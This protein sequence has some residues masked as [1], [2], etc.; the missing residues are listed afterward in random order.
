[1]KLRQYTLAGALALGILGGSNPA[2]LL[3]EFATDSPD[4]RALAEMN[5]CT[6]GLAGGSATP[7]GRPL[8]WKNRDVGN[9]NQEFHYYNDGRIP[10]I[11]VTYRNEVDEY[12]GGINA[13]GFAVENSNSYNLGGGA[14]DAGDW[15]HGGDDDGFIHTLA[16][17]TCRTVDDFGR[18]MDSLNVVGR[19]LTCNY[20]TI[21]AYGGAAMF[22]TAAY[23]YRRWDAI[24]SPEGFIVRSNY[25]YSGN[26]VNNRVGYWGPHRYDAAYALFKS[27]V[28]RNNL[29]P[30]YIYQNVI[31]NLSIEGLE[32]PTLPLNGYVP[33]YPFGCI[34]NGEAICRN[35]TRSVLVVQ[36]VRNGE[37]PDDAVMWAMAGSPLTA[38][39]V[40]VWVR[41]G[42]VPVELDGPNGSRICD[43]TISLQSKVYLNGAVNTWNL[44]NPSHTGLWDMTKPLEQW[45]Y[46][47]TQRFIHSPEFSY[48]QLEVFQ[49][50]M[51]RQVADSLANF[52]WATQVTEVTSPVFL[53]SNVVM[54][55]WTL[56][57][58]GYGRSP[59]G[60][61]IYR[62]GEPFREGLVG[63]P[64]AYTESN[65]FTD[66]DAPDQSCFYRVEAVF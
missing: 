12:Y 54:F 52:K 19:S 50:E 51:A 41:A 14:Y 40:P 37:R 61:N 48:D 30:L 46:N 59:R 13:E 53:R 11:S 8:L 10:F 56:P 34:P 29:T 33:G 4:I 15:A 22:E 28:E 63:E 1:M 43:T 47:K 27:A 25:S 39:A 31:R 58:N 35:S 6:T 49:N 21:D 18:L 44:T 24:D 20:G 17:A 3:K 2:G 23:T 32:N 62:S 5:E 9:G 55:N 60:Y 7:D 26:G 57:D 16:L 38:V 65:E 45:V 64:Y 42:S 66:S 36:G